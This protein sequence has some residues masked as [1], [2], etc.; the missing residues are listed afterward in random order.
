MSIPQYYEFN[1]LV[2][3]ASSPS[4]VHVHNTDLAWY[5]RRYLIQKIMSVFEW[6]NIPEHWDEDYLKYT[7]YM[8]GR[9]AVIN[10]DKFGAIPQ[11]CTLHGY[12][13]YYRP[14]NALITN[15]LIRGFKDPRIGVQCSLIKMQPDYGGAWD[16]V[17]YYADQMALASEALGV[18]MLNSKLAFV[19]AAENKQMAE[20][21]KKLYDKIASGEP[22][23][24]VDKDLF[25]DEGRL[26]MEFFNQNLKQTFIADQALGVL[27]AL[28]AG[29]DTMVGIPNVNI[30]KASGVSQSEVNAN[31]VDTKSLAEVWLNTMRRGCEQTN[32]LFGTNIDVS[33]HYVYEPEGGIDSDD[34][35]NYKY[36]SVV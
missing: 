12:D 30:A 3:S 10:T 16:I 6:H 1:N 8:F 5:F 24:V 11:Y 13:I 23:A 35:I 26:M 2:Q 29:F 19:F 34:E 9:V 21:F 18:N 20:S 31:N 14:T 4:A 15:P 17:S 7:I 25:N 32:K 36:L 27:A 28:D 22:A 33:F